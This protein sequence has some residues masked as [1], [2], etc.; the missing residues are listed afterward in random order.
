MKTGSGAFMKT[1]EDSEE[2]ARTMVALGTDAGC[3]PRR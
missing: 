3:A 1:R 2:L